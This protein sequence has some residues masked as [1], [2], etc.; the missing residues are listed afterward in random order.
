MKGNIMN[1]Q[2]NSFARDALKRGLAQLPEGH[3]RKFKQMYGHG[4]LNVNIND[5][6][7]NMPKDKL[8][9]AMRQVD[10]SLKKQLSSAP[11]E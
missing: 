3:Q 4:N 10:N 2:L 9:W 1:D 11:K 8:D 7:D 5:V 6:V